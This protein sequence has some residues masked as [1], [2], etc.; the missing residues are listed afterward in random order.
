MLRKKVQARL[1]GKGK[2]FAASVT[3]VHP[4]G[5]V[6]VEYPD[7]DDD[8]GLVPPSQVK[9]W[10][11]AQLTPEK[12]AVAPATAPKPAS[13]GLQAHPNPSYVSDSDSERGSESVS[14]AETNCLTHSVGRGAVVFE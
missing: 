8:V 6:D 14:Y 9:P 10:K 1:G 7:G 5:S 11:I 13:A 4:D 3:K 2:W 12:L